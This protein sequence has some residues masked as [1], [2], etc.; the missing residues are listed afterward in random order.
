MY[1]DG[2]SPY[3]TLP[4]QQ[5]PPVRDPTE[6]KYWQSVRDRFAHLRDDETWPTPPES[7]FAPVRLNAMAV[8]GDGRRVLLA[9][10]RSA[11]LLATDTM[12]AYPLPPSPET[13]SLAILDD[14]GSRAA[15][16]CE[17]WLYTCELGAT[18]ELARA[19][20]QRVWPMESAWY[21][22]YHAL[23][24]DGRILATAADRSSAT[25]RI[26]DLEARALVYHFHADCDEGIAIHP[27]GRHV[28]CFGDSG[29][30]VVYGQSGR[31][32]SVGR[33]GGGAVSR[34]GEWLM[35]SDLDDGRALVLHP[36]QVSD[37]HTEIGSGRVIR[38]GFQLRT[39]S[40][41]MRFAPDGRSALVQDND[42]NARLVD[43]KTQA[44]KFLGRAM[45][46]YGGILADGRRALLDTSEYHGSGLAGYRVGSLIDC[47]APGLVG[48]LTVTRRN[49][50]LVPMG[51]TWLGFYGALDA[52][53]SPL[54]DAAE[55][56]YERWQ[57]I[58]GL[59]GGIEREPFTADDQLLMD[60]VVTRD[61]L[62][63]RYRPQMTVDIEARQLMAINRGLTYLTA[64]I[65]DRARQ[66][67]LT[68]P[69]FGSP[70]LT[71][72]ALTEAGA[73]L[74]AMSR[75]QRAQVFAAML[76]RIR[77]ELA[78]QPA[79]HEMPTGPAVV[80]TAASAFPSPPRPVRSA[81]DSPELKGFFS[82]EP[83]A[84]DGAP[85]PLAALVVRPAQELDGPFDASD[86]EH[87]L[88]RSSWDSPLPT[89]S[90]ILALL[91]AL[92]SLWFLL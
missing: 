31:Q 1:P 86:E 54:A 90:I 24:R 62:W 59:L 22:E 46:Q 75:T 49:D 70:A 69:R 81:P 11:W 8:S 43:L 57:A 5:T 20:W 56:P 32:A 30:A 45:N 27:D 63:K 18:A 6:V 66:R 58:R 64:E 72:P 7:P 60:E 92:A 44:S 51:V 37:G 52:A 42:D 48:A 76:E 34:D 39:W 23:S 83:L 87:A 89:I 14:T 82:D 9:A 15:V 36:L 88:V 41:S 16:L 84:L 79:P 10:E 13:M 25:V 3:R 17:P 77:S 26:F 55:L 78:P 19:E 85:E 28:I 68:T 2:V 73:A 53:A 80:G 35:R 40:V 12:L 21:A 29:D 74:R 50:E 71:L 61:D 65:V 38:P 47:A 33:T 91:S 4:V 67:G